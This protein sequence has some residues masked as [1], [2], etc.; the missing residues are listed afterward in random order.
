M[1]DEKEEESIG[2]INILKMGHSLPK[3]NVTYPSK[4]GAD[5]ITIL[6]SLSVVFTGDST[7]LSSF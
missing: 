2:G 7:C 4:K 1:V 6:K 3:R 5:K